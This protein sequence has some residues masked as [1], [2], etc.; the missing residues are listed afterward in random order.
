MTSKREKNRTGR[1]QFY[2]VFF[3]HQ[4]LKRLHWTVVYRIGILLWLVVAGCD[5]F[6]RE[7]E[8]CHI[9]FSDSIPSVVRMHWEFYWQDGEL[10]RAGHTATTTGKNRAPK[11]GEGWKA[12]KTKKD[13]RKKKRKMSKKGGGGGCGL[14]LWEHIRSL[15]IDAGQRSPCDLPALPNKFPPKK[16]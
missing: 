7:V 9:F 14:I 13:K 12:K 5:L 10:K 11:K 1:T 4:L 2:R 8:T 16:Q 6:S 15:V 3:F